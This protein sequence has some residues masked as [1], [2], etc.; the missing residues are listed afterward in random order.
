MENSR[1]I[2]ISGGDIGKYDSKLLGRNFSISESEAEK[3]VFRTKIYDLEDGYIEKQGNSFKV[4]YEGKEYIIGEQGNTKSL[5]TSKTNLLHKVSCY[6]GITRLL[7]PGIKSDVYLVLACPISVL[8]NVEAK[9]E[10]KNFI[11]GEGEIKIVVDDKEYSFEI[12]DITI[13]AEGSGIL[14][15]NP[16]LFKNKTVLVVDLGGLNLTGALYVNG[17][18]TKDDRW[19]EECGVNRLIELTR[20]E[21][22]NYRKGNLISYEQSEQALNRGHLLDN[23]AIDLNSK[24]LINSSKERYLN[25]V[26]NY[27]KIHKIN[28]DE[29]DKVV[30]LGGTTNKIEGLIKEKI[31]HSYIPNESEIATL[32]GLYKVAFNKY[33]G[34]VK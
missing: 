2:I 5:D 6:T 28:I 34:K 12:K 9:E 7:E 27:I 14:Y 18:C 10:F 20:E 13:K 3:I 31:S 11:K 33:K 30:F 23:G 21:I 15:T 19:V 29:I 17:V 25:E 32:K 22:I 4:E 24:K 16:E 8:Q 1:H 26:L